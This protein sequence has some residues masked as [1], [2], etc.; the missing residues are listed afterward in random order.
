MAKKRAFISF[1]F[2]HDEDLRNLLVGQAKHPDS[3]FDIIDYSVRK[4]WAETSWEAKCLARIRKTEVVIILVGEYT[5]R[6]EGVITEI[7]LAKIAN[8]PYFGIHG[9]GD[10]RCPV[11]EG[12][13]KTYRWTWDNLKALISGE[14]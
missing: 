12:L 14:R 4:P 3:P 5:Y 8:V 7:N 10:K 6:A 11:P 13:N 1:D 9:R 2:D